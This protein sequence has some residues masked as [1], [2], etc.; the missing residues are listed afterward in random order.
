MFKHNRPYIFSE[1]LF[2][3]PNL[4]KVNIFF[5]GRGEDEHSL[6][7]V[8]IGEAMMA[9]SPGM[10]SYRKSGRPLKSKAYQS[11]IPIDA[12]TMLLPLWSL[13]EDENTGGHQFIED[14]RVGP[15]N[16][17][18]GVRLIGFP[19]EISIIRPTQLTLMN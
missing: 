2:E 9:Y 5:P 19:D 12:Q 7:M 18:W 10:W 13:N 6:E 15:E 16:R 8:P 1:S 11:M 17:P 3:P 4:N 14:H